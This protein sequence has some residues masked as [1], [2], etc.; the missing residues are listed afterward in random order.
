MTNQEYLKIVN[1]NSKKEPIFKNVII[2]SLI[3]GI[4]GVLTEFISFLFRN[5]CELPMKESY[6][7]TSVIFIIVST[8]LTG[9]GVMD[10]FVTFAKCGF[11][12][13][14]T[15]FAHSMTSA[16]LDYKREGFVK[17]I[18]GNIFKLTGSIILYTL[19]FAFIFALIKG[20]LL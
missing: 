10:K 13:P 12:I 8:L 1:K 15:G 9:A 19:I 2:A 14:I 6:I 18:G 7:I 20:V 17:G 3:G 5:Y 4:M 16:P 11:L